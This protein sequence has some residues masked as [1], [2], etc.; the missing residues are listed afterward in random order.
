M[1]NI[2]HYNVGFDWCSNDLYLKENIISNH[3]SHHYCTSAG[4]NFEV[5]DHTSK[6]ILKPLF[7]IVFEL[8]KRD[9]DLKDENPNY[10]FWSFVSNKKRNANVM[11]DHK[12]TSTANAVFYLNVP[13]T[14]N[15]KEG[16]L[17][18]KKSPSSKEIFFKPKTGDLIIFPSSYPHK[19][20]PI[21]TDDYRISI[22]M[23]SI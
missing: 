19:P 14:K 23:E 20:L 22:N 16:G 13:E 7:D 4:K 8:F 9:Y 21:Y 18:I 5:T 2:I 3:L 17:I 1:F 15:E 10:K 11:H 12:K 6:T